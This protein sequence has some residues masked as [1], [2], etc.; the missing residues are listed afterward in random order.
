[1]QTRLL[2]THSVAY[3]LPNKE[4]F[5]GLSLELYKGERYGL[6][7]PN[8]AGKTSLL[9]I[10]AAQNKPSL[11]SVVKQPGTDVY[12]M[13]DQLP[14]GKLWESAL[15]SLAKLKALEQT[16][17]EE[18]KQLEEAK[19]SLDNYARLV[20]EF[21]LK[22]GY[23][24]EQ[25]LK[26]HLSEF[27][28]GEDRYSQEV[29]TLSGGERM[30]LALAMALSQQ[31]DVLLLDEP[32]NHLDLAMKHYLQ[33]KL[34]QY[35]G[36]LVLASH[37]RA[38]LDAVCN[39]ILSLDQGQLKQYPGNYSAY[40]LQK[41]QE[42][43]TRKHQLKEKARLEQ[44]LAA[45]H[46]A[47]AYQQAHKRRK[48]LERSLTKLA[49]GEAQNSPQ[50]ALNLHER[51]STGLAYAAKYLTKQLDKLSLHI[52]KLQLYA[53]DKVALIG[54]NGSGKS[55]LFKLISGELESDHPK[56]ETF[57]HTDSKLFYF[58]Q[59]H[60]GLAE[61]QSL[62]E[63]LEYL[64]SSERAKMLLALVKLGQADWHKYP[65]EVSSGQKARAGIAKLIASEANVLLLDEPGNA[66]DLE[67]IELLENSLRDSSAT[68]L[69][70]SHDEA[71]IKNVCKDIWGLENGE[72]VAYRGG[73]SGYFKGTKY[74]P[75][76]TFLATDHPE[77]NEV[78]ESDEVRLERL[79]LERLSL[80]D[81]LLDPFLLS[82]RERERAKL[83][84][85]EVF[86]ELS[87]L[88]DAAYPEPLPRYQVSKDK[89][90]ISSNGFTEQTCLF[91]TAHEVGVR[92]QKPA[93]KAI[94]HILFLSPKDSCLVP[95]AKYTLLKAVIQI[96]FERLELSALQVQTSTDLS[97]LGFQ[98]AEANWWLMQRSHYEKQERYIQKRYLQNSAKRNAFRKKHKKGRQTKK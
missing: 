38:L 94:G 21:E 73:L 12:L 71:L 1:M 48:K 22:G 69:L 10:L 91:E 60:K 61:D 40:K 62:I 90:L 81:A 97:G 5:Y 31:A 51:R 72:L 8:G 18:E 28:F 2:E 47:P 79:E 17:R 56:L 53:G 77:P 42:A 7:G 14:A 24:A 85:K 63:G 95:W 49:P 19:G 9:K 33:K 84:Y 87:L 70:A 59:H 89:V 43:R 64:V 66:L 96:A 34:T 25:N 23:H 46:L 78:A 88:Y 26:K 3:Y 32:S 58:D 16:I 92:L 55:S 29:N 82:E 54:P 52:E 20:A 27:G 86:D 13:T 11:G 75:E 74:Q 6:I 98:A 44:S 68:I 41:D 30:R 45:S 35:P 67:L 80:E 15:S 93:D 83:R 65:H 39:K 76:E 50:A 36:A 4:L 37:D 57:W